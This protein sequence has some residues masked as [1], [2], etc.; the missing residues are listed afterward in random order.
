MTRQCIAHRR[1]GDIEILRKEIKAWANATN[2]KQR[3][4]DWQFKIDQ[5]RVKLKSL[6]PKFIDWQSTSAIWL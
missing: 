2:E 5:A 6:C 4:V 1:I 3:G